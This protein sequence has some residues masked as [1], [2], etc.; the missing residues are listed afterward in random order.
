MKNNKL[1]YLLVGALI[2]SNAYLFSI[3]LKEKPQG[4]GSTPI[5]NNVVSDIESDITKVAEETQNKVVSIITIRGNQQA[6]SGS[7]IVYKNESG[8]LK[9]V[10]NHHVVEGGTKHIVRFAN[11]EEFDAELM[12]SDMYTDLALLKVKADLEID[13]FTIGDSGLSKVGEFVIAIG[14]PLGVEFENSVTFGIISGK[15]RVVPVDLNNDGLSDWDMQ[16]LQTDAAINPGNSGGALVNMAGELIGI[17]SL[18]F[19]SDQVEGMG[20]SIPVNEMVPIIKQ[21]EEN[22]KVSYPIIGISAISI[23]DL[24]TFQKDRYKIPKDVDKGVL[25]MEATAGGP[26][27]KAELKQGDVIVKFG[28]ETVKSF[29]DFRRYL[30]TYKVGEKVGLEVLRDGVVVEVEVILE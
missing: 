27:D 22:G 23:T 6:G 19:S 11:G 12:G 4:D 28:N 29:K 9:I 16:V 24:N 15:N 8:V 5:I 17:N 2:V 30:Y 1:L 25:I 7:G 18:K 21:I 14:S 3:V 13:A 10:T 26:A 20:F